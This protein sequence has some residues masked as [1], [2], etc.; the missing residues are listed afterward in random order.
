M[1]VAYRDLCKVHHPDV[2]GCEDK[3]KTIQGAYEQC[4]ERIE[5][6]FVEDANDY[7]HRAEEDDES[8]A[9]RHASSSSASSGETYEEA[10]ESFKAA[11]GEARREKMAEL[12]Q[13]FRDRFDHVRDADDVDRL[14]DEA[15]ESDVFAVKDDGEPLALALNRYHHGM[16]LG[17]DHVA[18]CFQAM[19][20]WEEHYKKHCSCFFYHVLLTQYT[21]EAYLHHC[22]AMTVTQSV[23]KVMERMTEHGLPH[24]DWS[25]LLAN[26]AFR[27]MPFPDW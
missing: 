5:S 14:L 7:E 20:R 25:I 17:D 4:K 2:G 11:Q 21:N 12:R 3:F 13:R 19:G 6:G 8:A 16:P 10:Y 18:R 22:D 1:K 27:T 26:R 24:D 9:H 23:E 15:L